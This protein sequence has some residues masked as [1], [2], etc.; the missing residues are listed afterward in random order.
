MTGSRGAGCGAGWTT[1]VG[2]GSAGWTVYGEVADGGVVA[3]GASTFD[4]GTDGAGAAPLLFCAKA[5]IG[6][7]ARIAAIKAGASLFIP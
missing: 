7:A 5:G 1:I 3:G 4:G 2:A 6:N